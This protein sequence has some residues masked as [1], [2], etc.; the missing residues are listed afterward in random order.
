M[1]DS[2]I[3]S[4]FAAITSIG[5]LAEDDEET[6]LQKG[7][8]ILSSMMMSLFGIFWGFT[9][10]YYGESI[11]GLIPLGYSVLSALGLA[12]FTVV[13]RYRLFRASQL[14][15]SLLFPFLLMVALGGFADSS[16]VVM[17]SLTSPLGA[18]FFSGRRQAIP[19]FLAY[20][21]LLVLGAIVTPVIGQGNSLPPA[22]V[23]AFFALNIGGVSIVA[24]VLLQYFTAQKDEA[25][26]LLRREQEK[27][28]GLL[29][30][31]LPEKIA[32]VLKDEFRTIAE[33]FEA[34]S[35]L[36]AD[37]VGFTPLSAKLAPI[38]MVNTLNEAFSY[39]DT[40][41]AK[42]GLEKIRTVGDNYMVASGAPTPR[43]DHAPALVRMA[44]EMTEFVSSGPV[45]LTFRIGINS[46]P[47]VAGVIGTTKFHYD[48]WGDSVNTASRMESH[49]VPGSIQI[50]KATL[51]LLDD[52]FICRPRG[53]IEVK[54]KGGMETWLVEG[55][56][57]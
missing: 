51:D 23:N 11:A 46:G 43:P 15:F 22:V 38:E 8:L 44:L 45:P 1:K 18:L 39:F 24:F 55:L 56:R 35:V 20:I 10:F 7:I 21:F 9:Y 48:L 12:A 6:R 36:F 49:G 17:W 34:V 16:A 4:L 30:N 14:L 26:H 42:Y 40:L 50:T 57:K 2:S 33:Q 32:S 28:D 5:A 25:L 31:V 52:G 54:G 19:W 29:L 3:G 41:V 53:T 13:R 27:S 47:V 37:V